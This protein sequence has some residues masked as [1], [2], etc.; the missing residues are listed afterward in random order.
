[1]KSQMGKDKVLDLIKNLLDSEE[2]G[3]EAS[4][5]TSSKPTNAFGQA[6]GASPWSS[7]PMSIYG[8]G[9]ASTGLL[10]PPP[11]SF[12]GAP[13]G[14]PPGASMGVQSSVSKP[15]L[16][17]LSLPPPSVNI[18]QQPNMLNSTSTSNYNAQQ[19]PPLF[20]IP[21]QS[22]QQQIPTTVGGYQSHYSAAPTVGS[23][24]KQSQAT[25]KASY[26]NY[27]AAPAV[28][29]QQQPMLSGPPPPPPPIATASANPNNSQQPA[30]MTHINQQTFSNFNSQQQRFPNQNEQ[31]RYD[32]NFNQGYGAV[33]P[34][35]QQQFGGF[36]QMPQQQQYPPQGPGF[37]NQGYNQQQQQG[38]GYGGPQQQQ[39]GGYQNNQGFGGQ[40]HGGGNYG[41]GRY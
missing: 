21:P 40:G 29:N 24:A 17:S 18:Q 38:Y 28:Y 19:Q 20:N 15:S 12:S 25:Q 41:Q 10:G 34:N 32:D 16:M 6:P 22:T 33:G 36:G 37:N 7:T 26:P 39:R 30:F 2:D 8:P 11:V 35:T 1:M 31:Q 5:S 9:T 3:K 4:P 14:P 13:Q 27:Q 23:G